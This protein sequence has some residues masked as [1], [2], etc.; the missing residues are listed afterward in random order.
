MVDGYSRASSRCPRGFLV[1]VNSM[2][3]LAL[4]NELMKAF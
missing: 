1:N 3:E 4:R 2:E